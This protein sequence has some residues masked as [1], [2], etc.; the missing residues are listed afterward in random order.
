MTVY[1]KTGW[2]ENFKLGMETYKCS[3]VED[4]MEA[5]GDDPWE[6]ALRM[7]NGVETTIDRNA[8]VKDVVTTSDYTDWVAGWMEIWNALQYRGS[9]EEFVGWL[10]DLCEWNREDNGLDYDE[11]TARRIALAWYLKR[12]DFDI[13]YHASD[14]ERRALYTSE[15]FASPEKQ[16]AYTAGLARLWHVRLSRKAI[17]LLRTGDEWAYWDKVVDLNRKPIIDAYSYNEENDLS[18]EV[19]VTYFT[20]TH[21]LYPR[22]ESLVFIDGTPRE[23]YGRDLGFLD[24]RCSW[25]FADGRCAEGFD[26][27]W[28][29]K[30]WYEKHL[31]E[32]RQQKQWEGVEARD[33]EPMTIEDGEGGIWVLV[34]SR[35]QWANTPL[36][37]PVF[38]NPPIS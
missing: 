28:V 16:R 29:P 18:G 11:V 34:N 23:P 37:A 17:K 6:E 19:T 35:S 22:C 24:W 26:A 15:M 33:S 10:I 20:D 3:C 25:S 2:D 13:Y 31:P 32:M 30:T 38:V 9:V 14:S 27:R 4:W 7:G 12:L 36:G 1:A 21:D 5:H 8:W